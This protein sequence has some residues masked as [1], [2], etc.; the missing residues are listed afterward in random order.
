MPAAPVH[1]L[2]R[3]VGLDFPQLWVRANVAPE[4][5]RPL[6]RVLMVVPGASRTASTRQRL[7]SRKPRYACATTCAGPGVVR[8]D[9]R[10]S[11][12]GPARHALVRGRVSWRRPYRC[13]H[14]SSSKPRAVARPN[15]A[16]ASQCVHSAARASSCADWTRSGRM[17]RCHL[18]CAE[19]ASFGARPAGAGRTCSSSGRSPAGPRTSPVAARAC[20]ARAIRTRRGS[21]GSRRYLRTKPAEV[22]KSRCGC[23]RGGSGSRCGCGRG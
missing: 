11:R 3:K 1:P 18:H 15:H 4:C 13:V 16:H 2:V 20:A 7:L 17:R 21:S 5:P 22:G 12:G 9:M 8:H 19:R 14:D 10:W 23:G 6:R